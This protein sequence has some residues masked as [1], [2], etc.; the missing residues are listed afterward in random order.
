MCGRVRLSF[1]VSEI[2][3]KVKFDSDALTPMFEAD[4][5]K[6]PTAPMLIAPSIEESRHR[7]ID[8]KPMIEL[9]VLRCNPETNEITLDKLRWGLIPHWMKMR[10]ERQP[11]NACAETVAEK[12]MFSDAYARRRC[13][14]PM[15][16]FYERDKGR[17]QHAFGM[18]DGSLFGVAG[19][20]ENWRNQD[21]AWERTFCMI[22][23]PANELVATIHDR[24]PAIIPIEHHMRWLGPE[25]D[26]RDLLR[27]F[28]A[29]QLK[30][31]RRPN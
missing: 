17:K 22:T 18:K 26:P 1:D 11:I 31:F 4:F 19:I 25:P 29:D 14:V 2:K 6:E 24:M 23:A 20:W 15:D 12:P 8:A 16:R 3:I 9:P 28:P 27:P 7:K 21:G 5:N 10:P 13:I 30:I